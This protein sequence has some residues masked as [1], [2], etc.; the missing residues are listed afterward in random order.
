MNFS[1]VTIPLP[2]IYISQDETDIL[3]E[4]ERLDEEYYLCGGKEYATIPEP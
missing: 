3:V 4:M 2:N 1:P